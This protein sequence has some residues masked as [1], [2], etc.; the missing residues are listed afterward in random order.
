MSNPKPVPASTPS[1]PDGVTV[2][3]KGDQLNILISSFDAG[4]FKF[5]YLIIFFLMLLICVFCITLGIQFYETT[6]HQGP[7][8]FFNIGTFF[9]I[10]IAGG[11]IFYVIIFWRKYSVLVDANGIRFKNLTVPRDEWGGFKIIEQASKGS[12]PAH[13]IGFTRD[14][15][16]WSLGRV[17]DGNQQSST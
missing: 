9:I 12:K 16:D 6:G 15:R 5:R 3:L 14:G 13:L 4:L 10:P 2:W 7:S 1:A 8:L 11:F 17:V